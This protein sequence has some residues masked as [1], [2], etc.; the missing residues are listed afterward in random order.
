MKLGHHYHIKAYVNEGKHIHPTYNAKFSSLILDLGTLQQRIPFSW[1]TRDNLIPGGTVT[2]KQALAGFGV[3]FDVIVETFFTYTTYHL[4]PVWVHWTLE[5]SSNWVEKY[6]S[7]KD[8]MR[9]A[10]APFQLS[11]GEP[12]HLFPLHIKL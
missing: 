1:S 10:D 6:R 2:H 12:V 3:R 11:R 7:G 4:N 5:C 8:D 9:T